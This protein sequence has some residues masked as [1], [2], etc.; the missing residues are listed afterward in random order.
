VAGEHYDRR[1]ETVPAQVAQA[2]SLRNS[3]VAPVASPVIKNVGRLP[4]I[5]RAG[6]RSLEQAK[7]AILAA[8]A[9]AMPAL[10]R[11]VAMH[12]EPDSCCG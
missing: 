9:T 3:H 1:L 5:A 4:Q 10:D 2:S 6:S 8:L 12:F 7:V 11:A